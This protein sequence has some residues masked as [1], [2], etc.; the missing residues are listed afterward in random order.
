[1][2]AVIT[3]L[4]LAGFA[5]HGRWGSLALAAVVGIM[6]ASMVRGL[7]RRRPRVVATTDELRLAIGATTIHV[8]WGLLLGASVSRILHR[9]TIMIEVSPAWTPQTFI[10]GSGWLIGLAQRRKIEDS[11]E[12]LVPYDVHV[13]QHAFAEWLNGRAQAD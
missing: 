10:E 4:L 12:M 13:D 2:G 5:S 9:R 6:T 1:V 7:L 3:A 8:P 11:R